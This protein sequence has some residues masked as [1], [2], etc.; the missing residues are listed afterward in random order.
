LYLTFFSFAALLTARNRLFLSVMWDLQSDINNSLPIIRS[1]AN[2]FPGP[3]I[4]IV[5]LCGLTQDGKLGVFIESDI[6]ETLSSTGIR[7]G[8][9][10]PRSCIEANWASLLSEN[11]RRCWLCIVRYWEKRE[12]ERPDV[13]QGI[14][15][16]LNSWRWG[17]EEVI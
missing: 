2:W 1:T 10:L 16:Q 14:R 8:N 4:S 11:R 3:T 12:I 7:N 5:C 9:L 17:S 13:M 15:K 6:T